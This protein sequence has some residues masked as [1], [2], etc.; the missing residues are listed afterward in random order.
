MADTPSPAIGQAFG[1]QLG[2]TARPWRKPWR[3]AV[4]RK[5]MRA[6]RGLVTL[7]VEEI[8]A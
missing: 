2:C 8:P 6:R 7:L 3:C 4:A 1:R 5:T